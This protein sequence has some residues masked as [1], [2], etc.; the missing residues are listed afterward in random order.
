MSS[1]D[2]PQP[3]T[4]RD[5]H[6]RQEELENEML[7][8]FLEEEELAILKKDAE[9]KANNDMIVEIPNGEDYLEKKGG[10]LLDYEKQIFLDT[11]NVDG[12]AVFGK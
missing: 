11:V 2:E 8:K 7:N 9:T 5:A 10:T 1:D 6:L 12:L 3:G 4:S